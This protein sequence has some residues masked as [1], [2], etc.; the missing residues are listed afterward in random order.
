MIHTVSVSQAGG[1]RCAPGLP[2]TLCGI[3]MDPSEEILSAFEKYCSDRRKPTL[4]GDAN[5]YIRHCLQKAARNASLL[6]EEVNIGHHQMF[7]MMALKAG[8]DG[9]TLV[10]DFLT[11]LAS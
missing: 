3:V 9:P 7:A 10:V 5:G 11:A 1:A 8:D 4:S 6:N 2:Y